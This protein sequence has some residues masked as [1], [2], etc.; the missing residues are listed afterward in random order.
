MDLVDRDIQSA[1]CCITAFGSSN[2]SVSL[3]LN[4]L[5]CKASGSHLSEIGFSL[6]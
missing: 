4:P 2:A 6:P 5:T 3:R 1:N